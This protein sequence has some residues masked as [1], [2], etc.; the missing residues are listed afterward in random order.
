MIR[1]KAVIHLGLVIGLL[2]QATAFA[3][4]SDVPLSHPNSEAI[5][6]LQNA[7]IVEGYPPEYYFYPDQKINR[8]EFVK[9]LTVGLHLNQPAPTPL[10]TCTAEEIFPDVSRTAWYVSFTCTAR[11]LGFIQGYPDGRFHGERSINFVEAAKILSKA[12]SLSIHADAKIW[13]KGYVQALEEKNAIPFSISS[14]DQ[15]ITRGEMAE[16]IWRL[17]AGVTTKDSQTYESLVRS[18]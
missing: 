11:R 2:F 17:K 4:F 6:F 13:Y 3:A 10:G 15:H 5:L 14:F 9:V 12:F 1:P 16:I 8:A 18:T 7:G